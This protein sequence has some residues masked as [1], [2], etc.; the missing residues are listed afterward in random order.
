MGVSIYFEIFRMTTID[1]SDFYL[2]LLKIISLK[3][4]QALG[5]PPSDYLF[6]ILKPFLW[7]SNINSEFVDKIRSFIFYW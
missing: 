5:F 3:G 7:Q 1:L 2:L 4:L 6:S